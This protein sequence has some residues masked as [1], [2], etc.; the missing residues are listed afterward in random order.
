MQVAQDMCCRSRFS[1]QLNPSALKSPGFLFSRAEKISL[2]MGKVMTGIYLFV[3]IV[4][5]P[6]AKALLPP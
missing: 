1:R 6:T 5:R 3:L 4:M 2:F